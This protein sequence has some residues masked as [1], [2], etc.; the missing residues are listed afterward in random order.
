MYISPLFIYMYIYVY[1]SLPW[2]VAHVSYFGIVFVPSLAFHGFIT[3][4]MQLRML[5]VGYDLPLETK[6]AGKGRG[7]GR[8]RG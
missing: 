4:S 1:L 3:Y 7:R 6:A 8:G 5:I 2:V